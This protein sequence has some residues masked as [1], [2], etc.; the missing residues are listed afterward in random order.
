MVGHHHGALRIPLAELLLQ[1]QAAGVVPARRQRRKQPVLALPVHLGQ[2]A[3]LDA[4]VV[5]HALAGGVHGLELG[6]GP[7]QGKVRPEGAAQETDAGDRGAAVLQVMDLALGGQGPHDIQ[8]PVPVLAVELVVP[9]DID[10]RGVRKRLPGPSQPMRPFRHVPRQDHHVDAAQ[11]LG[12]QLVLE[13]MEIEVQ[14]GVDK[15]SHG[16]ASPGMSLRTQRP[17]LVCS[18]SSPGWKSRFSYSPS[19]HPN[20]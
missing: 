18:I 12:R 8:V 10:D 17:P 14:V 20:G 2:R 6:L 9:V 15:H 7:G 3:D 13:R 19:I 4:P 1:P 16:V 5:V 11:D